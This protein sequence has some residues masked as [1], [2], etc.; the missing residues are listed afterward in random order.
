MHE[1]SARL[2]TAA[3]QCRFV[4]AL[5]EFCLLFAPA[6]INSCRSCQLSRAVA[7]EVQG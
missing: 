2:G 4:H 5:Q 6:R 3:M 1:A 7:A